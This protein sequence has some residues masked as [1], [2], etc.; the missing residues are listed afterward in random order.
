MTI[1]IIEDD[2]R[3][4]EFVKR[5]LEAEGY[6]IEFAD[7]GELGLQKLANG[8]YDLL[9]LDLMLPDMSGHDVCRQLRQQGMTLP[10]LMLTAMDSLEDKIE[11]LHLGADDYLTKPFAFDELVARI[12]ALLR[13]NKGAQG[14]KEQVTELVVAGLTLNRDTR[15][16]Y[17]EDKQIELTPKEYALLEY[18]MQSPGRV[19]S[20][21]QILDQVW[22]Y[23][24]D[25]LT[26]IVEVY[27]RNLR[28]KLGEGFDSSL[29]KTVRGFGYKLELSTP[30]SKT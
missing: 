13:R 20:R 11:G 12:K 5:G 26:N 19:F 28:R 1:L 16:V 2:V 7:N 9:L 24:A 8:V 27:I 4:L 18:F 10:V 22:G 14:Y 23:N 30:G 15:E 29:I 3:I 6:L 21:S 25:P 17:R